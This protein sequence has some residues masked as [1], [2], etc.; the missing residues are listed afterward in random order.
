MKFIT[1]IQSFSDVITNSSSEVFLMHS[2]DV[3]YYKKEGENTSCIETWYIKDLDWI[4]ENGEIFDTLLTDYLNIYYDYHKDNWNDIVNQ[5]SEEFSKLIGLH[6]VEIEDHF[7]NWE[8]VNDD[9]HNRCIAWE[10]RH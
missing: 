4:K 3:G 6:I 1:S 8:E 9:A 2:S 10:S 7:G 5:Y